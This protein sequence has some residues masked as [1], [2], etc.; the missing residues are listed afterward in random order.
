M[1]LLNFLPKKLLENFKRELSIKTLYN[2][3]FFVIFWIFVLSA[4][5]FTATKFLTIQ[6]DSIK[7]RIAMTQSLRD[8]AEAEK[9]ENEINHINQLALRLNNIS[10][11]YPNDFP[12]LLEILT[13]MVPSGSNIKKLVFSSGSESNIKLEGHSA[14]RTHIITLQERLETSEFFS[15]IEAPLSNLLKAEDID[16]QFIVYLNKNTDEN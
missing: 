6:T 7:D 4:T 9:L 16:F 1:I 3:T 13:P 15:K 5:I 11:K 10:S 14:L 8:T 2:A 12:E